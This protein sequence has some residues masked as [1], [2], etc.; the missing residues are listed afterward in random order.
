[1]CPDLTQTTC[2]A[3]SRQCSNVGSD[4][5]PQS[6]LVGGRAFFDPAVFA[7]ESDGRVCCQ[8]NGVC[9]DDIVFYCFVPSQQVWSVA[10]PVILIILTVISSSVASCH[11]L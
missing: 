9:L 5:A 10:S 2:D 3:E 8:E 7:I 4:R 11:F 1:V 6:Q